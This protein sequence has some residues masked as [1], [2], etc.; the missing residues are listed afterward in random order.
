M[1]VD[2]LHT[3]LLI[4]MRM[5]SSDGYNVALHVH[6]DFEAFIILHCAAVSDEYGEV[7]E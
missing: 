2:L 3:K 4:Y 6:V 5:T 1:A 7:E